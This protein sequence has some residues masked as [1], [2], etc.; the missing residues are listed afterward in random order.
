MRKKA[1]DLF[2][3]YK[4]NEGNSMHI[5]GAS[6]KRFDFAMVPNDAFGTPNKI[7]HNFGLIGLINN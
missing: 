5:R 1:E 3:Y 2:Y 6:L 4:R 7:P